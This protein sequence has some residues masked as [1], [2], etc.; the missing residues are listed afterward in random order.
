MRE[1][2]TKLAHNHLAL[3][4]NWERAAKR[5]GQYFK[6]I[7]YHRRAAKQYTAKAGVAV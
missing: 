7:N 3:A 4:K 2:Y 6:Q 1:H 5:T